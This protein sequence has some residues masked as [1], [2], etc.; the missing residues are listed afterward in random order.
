MTKIFRALCIVSFLLLVPYQSF[1]TDASYGIFMVVKGD[2]KIT[3]TSSQV[4]PAKVGSKIFP[5]ET[6][7]S[8]PDSRA[9]IVMSDRNVIN[10]SPDTKMKISK[11][12][13]DATTGTKNVELNLLEGKVRNN[14]EQTYD[15]EKSKFLIKT[16]TAVAGVRGTQFFTSF[17]PS[18]RMTQIV[19][20]KGAVSFNSISAK[21]DAIGAAVIVKKGESTSAAAGAAPEQPKVVPKEEMKK[22]DAESTASNSQK[23]EPAAASADRGKKE[24]AKD[25]KE[26][27][28]KDSPKD[29][30]K[31]GPKEVVKDGSGAATE[32]GTSANAAD[33]TTSGPNDAK[34]E[35]ASV[36]GSAAKPA[37]PSSS[38][39]D[40]RDMDVGMAKD[41]KNPVAP[42]P[43]PPPSVVKAPTQPPNNDVIR[44]IMRDS[45]TKVQVI[46]RPQPQ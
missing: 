17:D 2:V 43:P 27:V 16:P 30:P 7:S 23:E 42:P 14:V 38:M 28:A 36:D 8:G 40:K 22:I 44:N 29:A 37:P 6:V 19:T 46:V 13:N 25:K 5:G 3:N 10:I 11:Y 24:D 9:K 1:A 41:I 35:V 15:G 21:G 12:E 26:E 31:D 20:L 4:N 18:T 34:R 32:K 45:A 39:I 33:K